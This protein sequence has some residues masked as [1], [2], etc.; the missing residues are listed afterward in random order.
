MHIQIPFLLALLANVAPSDANLFARGSDSLR[1][2]HAH[3]AKRSAS[4]ARDLRTTFGTIFVEQNSDTTKLGSARVYCVSSPSNNGT[5]LTNGT[6]LPFPS[7]SA[8]FAP[9]PSATGPQS[10][11]TSPRP[12]NSASSASPSGTSVPSS[13]WK[14]VQSF[15]SSIPILLPQMSLPLSIDIARKLVLHWM[16]FLYRRRPHKR[17]S[18]LRRPGHCSTSPISKPP[19]YSTFHPRPRS[20]PRYAN[21]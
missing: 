11:G 5:S 8:T 18:H 6:S 7:S 17:T 12:T 3:A 4:F 19:S 15:V 9:T 14:V 21:L 13:P 2:V 10:N 1:R 16:G 20:C